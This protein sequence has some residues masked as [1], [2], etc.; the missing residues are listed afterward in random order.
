MTV[1]VYGSVVTSRSVPP[2]PAPARFLCS[3][4]SAVFYV[5]C[6]SILSAS[7]P[8]ECERYSG[9]RHVWGCGWGWGE[10]VCVGMGVVLA[11]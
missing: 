5:S 8:G 1:D 9:S 3:V 4:I 6:W 7:R 10:C 2:S 11:L